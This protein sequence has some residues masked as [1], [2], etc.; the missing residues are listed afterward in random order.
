VQP[1]I[2]VH[3]FVVSKVY[4]C[5]SD[6]L[7]ETGGER[8]HK[9]GSEFHPFWTTGEARAQ[10]RLKWWDLGSQPHL[11]RH[12]RLVG[13]ALAAKSTGSPQPLTS[14]SMSDMAIFVRRDK[15]A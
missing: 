11:Q 9:V 10:E 14:G 12:R 8:P 3:P 1:S 15:P 7:A 13:A 5:T 2:L 4:L 6:Q